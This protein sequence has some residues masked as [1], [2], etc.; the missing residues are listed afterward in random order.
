M[1]NIKELDPSLVPRVTPDEL[2]QRDPH[3]FVKVTFPLDWLTAETLIE[4]ITPMKS[5]NG[6]LTPLKSTN[7]LEALDAVINLRE[8]RDL[9]SEVQSAENQQRL[10]H[11]FVLQYARA[12]EVIE[13]LETLLGPDAKGEGTPG[14]QNPQGGENPQQQQAMMMARLQQ[15]QQQQQQGG[16]GG[17]P[18][19]A[20]PKQVVMLVLN[21]RRNSI[22]AKAPPDKMAI[23]AQAINAIDVPLD[24]TQSLLTN[25]NRMQ[26]YRIT[27]VDPEPVV[28]TLQ[29][30]GN[31]DPA[32]RLQVDKKNKAIVAYATLADH[33]TIRSVVEKLSGSERRFEVVRLH[34]LPADYVAGSI[35]FMMVGEKKEKPARSR[36]G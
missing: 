24:T 2:D 7:R 12:S 15:Q 11:E 17:A 21:Q 8:I 4:E 22:L 29:E 25:V 27:G 26:V 5:P 14:G 16:Q 10:V 23:I 3:E 20:K 18:G 35:M 36:I 34:H 32:T 31:L 6:K 1:A 9:L 33:V 13:Q 28:K 30:I 19:L